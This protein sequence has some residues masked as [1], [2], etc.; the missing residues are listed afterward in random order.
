MWILHVES[1]GVQTNL[2]PLF[3]ADIILIRVIAYRLL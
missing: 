1:F 3:L 2:E